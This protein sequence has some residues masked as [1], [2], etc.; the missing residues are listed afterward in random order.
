MDNWANDNEKVKGI[1]TAI[2]KLCGDKIE[3]E[4]KVIIV[5]PIVIELTANNLTKIITYE[6]IEDAERYILFNFL[7]PQRKKRICY[8]QHFIES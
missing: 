4:L 5:T 7:I 6:G 2:G 3:W 8:K 1:P